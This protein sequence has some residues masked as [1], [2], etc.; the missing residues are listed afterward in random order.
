M[1][2]FD[3]VTHAN[4]C[5][6]F[7]FLCSGIPK[8]KFVCMYKPCGLFALFVLFAKK[9][10]T[11]NHWKSEAPVGPL[12]LWNTLLLIRS[13]LVPMQYISFPWS[14]AEMKAFFV[15]ICTY[16]WYILHN[17]LPRNSHFSTFFLISPISDHI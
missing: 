7:C 9:K 2:C 6:L 1:T 3:H 11:L 8:K 13:Y 12:H 4:N 5:L 15:S 14:V 17:N 16:M 10:H